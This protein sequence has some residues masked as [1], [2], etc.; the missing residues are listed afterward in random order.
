M[1]LQPVTAAL[2]AQRPQIVRGVA[3]VAV[4]AVP[5]T[6]APR[7]QYDRVAMEV[8]LEHKHQHG[9]RQ[10]PWKAFLARRFLLSQQRFI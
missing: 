7:L 10:Q 3:I 2:P 1:H 5:C 4:Q 9:W 6:G 8:G